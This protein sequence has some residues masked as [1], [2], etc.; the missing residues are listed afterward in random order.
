MNAAL[1]CVAPVKVQ[2]V[3]VNRELGTRGTLTAALAWPP[4]AHCCHNILNPMNLHHLRD[5]RLRKASVW[6]SR[7]PAALSSG[8]CRGLLW[9][10]VSAGASH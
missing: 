8:V 3:A 5:S 6:A 9:S 2:R 1:R 10:A 4:L 7:V